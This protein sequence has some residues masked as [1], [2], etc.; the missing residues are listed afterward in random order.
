MKILNADCKNRKR[1]STKKYKNVG[2]LFCLSMSEDPLDGLFK[3]IDI[4]QSGS[5]SRTFGM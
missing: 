3:L 5:N 4:D 1:K 2:F